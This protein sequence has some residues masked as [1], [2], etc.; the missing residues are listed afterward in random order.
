M[1]PNT[2]L[3]IF[4]MSLAPFPGISADSPG[5]T[6]PVNRKEIAP[7]RVALAGLAHGHAFGFFDQ[8]QHRTD[9]QVV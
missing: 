3:A 1:R 8:F 9:L 7:L 6:A 5:Q 4:L 2:F